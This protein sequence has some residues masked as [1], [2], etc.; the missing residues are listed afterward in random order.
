MIKR[1]ARVFEIQEPSSVKV[2]EVTQAIMN[3]NITAS[4]SLHRSGIGCGVGY[5][6]GG[7]SLVEA[8]SIQDGNITPTGP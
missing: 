4:S 5:L 7:T 2:R 1:L 8:V 6:S 3:G